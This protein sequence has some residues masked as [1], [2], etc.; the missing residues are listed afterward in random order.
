MASIRLEI[1]ILND[2][3]AEEIVDRRRYTKLDFSRTI[4]MCSELAEYLK[5]YKSW[6]IES[7]KVYGSELIED[8][9]YF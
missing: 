4:N 9:M 3:V 6:C 7:K 8:D 5:S 2:A 1:C